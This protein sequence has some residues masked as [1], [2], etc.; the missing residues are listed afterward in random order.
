[1]LCHA[2][3]SSSTAVR[4]LIMPLGSPPSSPFSG[5]D[6]PSRGR[7][8]AYRLAKWRTWS[9][10]KSVYPSLGRCATAYSI[11]QTLKPTH[12]TANRYPEQSSGYPFSFATGTPLS[13]PRVRGL[14]ANTPSRL[15]SS[16]SLW[17]LCAQIAAQ[18]LGHLHNSACAVRC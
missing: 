1:M 16:N 5:R 4:Q 8:A 14:A 18:G 10:G 13:P 15:T 2:M 6:A 9:V 12:G 7:Y 11:W 3:P 17:Q